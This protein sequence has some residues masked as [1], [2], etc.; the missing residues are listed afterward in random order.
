MGYIIYG[1]L[2]KYRIS[3]GISGFTSHAAGYSGLPI[4]LLHL[5]HEGITVLSTSLA[6]YQPTRYN[7]RRLESL[8]EFLD[9]PIKL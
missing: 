2:E 7:P 4:I 5:E 3:S 8:G 1:I 9:R 6:I